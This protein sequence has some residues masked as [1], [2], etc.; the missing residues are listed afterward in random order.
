MGILA[1]ALEQSRWLWPTIA[2]FTQPFDP[3]GHVF[4]LRLGNGRF[5]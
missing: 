1:L 2:A 4:P 5:I 3:D